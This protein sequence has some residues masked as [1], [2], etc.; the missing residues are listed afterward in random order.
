MDVF[1]THRPKLFA[2]AYKM[3]KS[4]AD[5]EDIVQDLFLRYAEHPPEGIRNT[6]AY[7]VKAV[8]NRSLDRLEKKKREVY[9]GIDLPEPLFAKQFEPV[10]DYDVS[11]ALLLLLQT[12]NPQERAVFLLHETLDY[13]YPEIAEAL[14]LREDHCR[15]LLHR[16]KEKVAAGKPRNRPSPEERAALLDAFVKGVGSDMR[17]LVDYLKEDIVIY[18]DGGGKVAA[19][20]KP[21]EGRE[22]CLL[23]MQ[24]LYLK[25]GH[26]FY[27]EPAVVNGEIGIVLRQNGTGAVDTV[28]LPDFDGGEI[29]NFYFI[30]NPDKLRES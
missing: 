8:M 5:A 29:A 2:V 6:E 30:R 4:V 21:I 17:L 14:D 18:S 1:E 9:T 7:W 10:R 13:T 3:T 24:G 15:Q 28:M 25:F 16:A 27:M 12:L 23:F 11:Y 22:K 20:L 26:T 19:A